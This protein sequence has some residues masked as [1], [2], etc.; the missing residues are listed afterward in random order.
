MELSEEI[1]KAPT[2]PK[3]PFALR[4][5]SILAAGLFGIYLGVNLDRGYLDTS[6]NFLLRDVG[7]LILLVLSFIIYPYFSNKFRSIVFVVVGLVMI[8]ADIIVKYVAQNILQLSIEQ[9]DHSNYQNF[10]ERLR[11]GGIVMLILGVVF[12]LK[13]KPKNTIVDSAPRQPLASKP[14]KHEFPLK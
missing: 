10:L 3:Q 6:N 1:I 5:R 8:C 2:K 9:I 13:K 7:P 12:F 11:V 14:L 4:T